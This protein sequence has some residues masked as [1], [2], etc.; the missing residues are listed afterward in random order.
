MERKVIN[1]NGKLSLAGL[2]MP[3]TEETKVMKISKAE[4]AAEPFKLESDIRLMEEYYRSHQQYRNLLYFVCGIHFGLRVSDMLRL[5]W[6]SLLNNDLTFR[7]EIVI[8]EKKTAHTRKRS[9]NRHIAI[10][11]RVKEIAIEYLEHQ[12]LL[13]REITLDTYLFRSESNNSRGNAPMHRSKVDVF[14]KKAAKETGVA[15]RVRVSTHSVRKTFCYWSLRNGVSVG[16]LQK[17]LG[18]RSELQTLTY[19][20]YTADTI[21]DAYE[22]LTFEERRVS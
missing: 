16:M 6:G 7:E 15:D 2:V 21:R 4:H 12:K 11:G 5:T 14:L 9:F 13:G 8:L 17:I 1:M 20:G 3:P 10:N 19:A 22:N 18:H